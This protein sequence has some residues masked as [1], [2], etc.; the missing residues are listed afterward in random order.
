MHPCNKL[1]D[2]IASLR[3]TPEAVFLRKVSA[4]VTGFQEMGRHEGAPK[5]TT[6]DWKEFIRVSK[7]GFKGANREILIKCVETAMV[8]CTA[9]KGDKI[10]SVFILCFNC[11]VLFVAIF[12]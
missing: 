3:A 5:M 6:P 12:S 1:R 9:R 2:A 10:R 7:E 11:S 4:I 8:L